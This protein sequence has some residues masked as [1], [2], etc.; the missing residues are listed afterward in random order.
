MVMYFAQDLAVERYDKAIAPRIAEDERARQVEEHN[1]RLRRAA[2]EDAADSSAVEAQ[3]GKIL[4]LVEVRSW[5]M[6]L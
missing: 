3:C 4:G 1:L 5:R 6:C 2:A